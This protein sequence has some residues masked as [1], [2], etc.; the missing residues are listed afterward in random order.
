MDDGSKAIMDVLNSGEADE[1]FPSEPRQADKLS[2]KELGKEMEIR[3]LKLTGFYSEDA[4]K[5]QA[6]FDT[7]WKEEKVKFDARMAELEKQRA[8]AIEAALIER[9]ILKEHMEEK[10]DLEE[11]PSKAHLLNS[12]IHST[13]EKQIVANLSAPLCRVLAKTIPGNMSLSHIC[14]S[15]SKIGD[16]VCSRLV[17]A[18]ETVP[19]I[20]LEIEH[21]GA[22]PETAQAMGKYL[23]TNETMQTL[24]LENN[25]LTWSSRGQLDYSGVERFCDGLSANQTLRNLFLRS[26]SLQPKGGSKLMKCLQANSTILYLDC[27]NSGIEIKDEHTIHA[28]LRRNEAEHCELERVRK[29]EEKEEQEREA[30]RIAE[31]KRHA[32]AEEERVWLEQ[33]KIERR[34]LR[35]KKLADERLEKQEREL[36]ALLEEKRRAE[37]AQRL[38]KKKKKKGK[39]KKK[40]GARRGRK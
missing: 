37:E 12:V 7:E 20:I 16:E 5:L 32:K 3:G 6:V 14:L 10:R 2:V 29:L 36:A 33:R 25:K 11:Y 13:T 15:H 1:K 23:E 17:N 24:N 4:K 39:G 19:L 22:G 30:I 35:K 27:Q 18:L 8:E 38:K 40:K 9:V 34:E 21:V 26:T 28:Y 31:E